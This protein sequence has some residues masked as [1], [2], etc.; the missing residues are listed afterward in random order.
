L[1][2]PNNSNNAVDVSEAIA[3]AVMLAGRKDFS[4][5]LLLLQ[6]AQEQSPAEVRI[7]PHMGRIVTWRHAQTILARSATRAMISP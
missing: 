1:G 4:E 6:Q 5:A 3:H 7:A 2:R